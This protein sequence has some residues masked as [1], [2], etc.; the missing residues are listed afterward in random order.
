MLAGNVHTTFSSKDPSNLVIV[1]I[2][3]VSIQNLLTCLCYCGAIS[4]IGTLVAA[5]TF[6][7]L[8]FLGLTWASLEAG[9]LRAILFLAFS[10][11][12]GYIYQ[13]T[14]GIYFFAS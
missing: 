14:S 11:T 1:V 8:G 3:L 13:V 12:C 5:Y 7:A 4:P 10:I 9:S 6:L 2:F